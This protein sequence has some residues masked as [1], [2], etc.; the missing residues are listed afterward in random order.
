MYN[1]DTPTRADLPTTGRLIRSTLIAVAT[2]AVLLVTVILPAEYA[3]DPT[4]IGR[5]L[6]LTKMGEIK[7]QL[8]QEA[9]RDALTAPVDAIADP[10]IEPTVEAAPAVVETTLP[11][12]P[13]AALPA[14]D[15]WRDEIVLT[16]KPGAAA[17]IKLVMKKGETASYMWIV[18]QGHLNSD[19]HGDGVN[20][21]S[22]SY[23]KGRAESTD[24]GELTSA[25]DGAHGWFWRNRSDVSVALTLQVKGEYSE[26]KRAL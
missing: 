15:I 10:A 25:F 5:V 20:G 24:A 4:G 23:R 16:L 14:E 2:A 6:G 3:V 1:S 9:E 22:I 21:R 18:D 19:L 26:V 11:A 12:S 17:E 13:L 8:A 7:Q